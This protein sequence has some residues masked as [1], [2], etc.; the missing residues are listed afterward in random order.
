MKTILVS[1]VLAGV[2]LAQVQNYKPVTDEMLKNPSANDWL[3]FSR[4]YD[5]NRFSPLGQINKGNVGKL[6]LAWSRGLTAG[7]TEAIPIVHDGVMYIVAPGAVVQALDATTGD[8]L[9]EYKHDVPA[10]VASSARTKTIAVYQDIICIPT[11]QAI[12]STGLI[13]R[14]KSSSTR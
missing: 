3:M 10:S 14:V 4:T 6:A 5:A 11:P 8:I 1:A 13:R 12:R 7:S 2:A 9:W